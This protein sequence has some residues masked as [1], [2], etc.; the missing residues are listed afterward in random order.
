MEKKLKVELKQAKKNLD[1]WYSHGNCDDPETEE[2]LKG[3]IFGLEK[4]MSIYAK[5]RND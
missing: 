1:T 5:E 4:A 2:W 3:I